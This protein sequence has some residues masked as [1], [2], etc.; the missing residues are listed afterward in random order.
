MSKMYAG[1]QVKKPVPSLES[2]D[3]FESDKPKMLMRAFVV[4]HFNYC[5]ITGCFMMENKIGPQQLC[6][7]LVV[8]YS[9][10]TSK[11]K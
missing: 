10:L 2:L 3:I 8:S 1:R 6:V 7:V 9:L 11:T 4:S 5:P